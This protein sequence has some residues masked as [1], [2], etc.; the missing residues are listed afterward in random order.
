MLVGV[1][2]ALVILVLEFVLFC[3]WI[4]VAGFPKVLDKFFALVVSRELLESV[5]FGLRE[6]GID[7]V[8]P[9]DLS[10]F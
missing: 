5:T 9:I 8:K 3:V 7:I 1:N 4:I 10:L 2:N 6:N